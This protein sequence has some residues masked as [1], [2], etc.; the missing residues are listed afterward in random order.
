MRAGNGFLSSG[1]PEVY[2]SLGDVEGLDFVRVFWPSGRR[3]AITDVAVNQV[4]EL[5]EP[6]GEPQE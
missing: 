4:L 3:L 5:E 6:Q 1:A 2:F